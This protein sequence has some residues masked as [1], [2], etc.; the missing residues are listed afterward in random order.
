MDI[1]VI[2]LSSLLLFIIIY[3]AIRLAINP[4]L[5]KSEEM[6]N[7]NQ[8]FELVKLRDIEVLSDSELEEVIELY[9]KKSVKKE[10]YEQYQKYA[11]V[12]NELRQMSYFTEE[13]HFDKLNRL[14]DYFK[15][16]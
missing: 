13:L 8:D 5:N 16:N 10:D 6:I 15:V 12:L 9:Q 14:K 1:G 7:D 11:K 3:S 4:L 2:L